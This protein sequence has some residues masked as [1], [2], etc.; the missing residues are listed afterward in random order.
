MARPRLQSGSRLFMRRVFL[1]TF[2]SPTSRFFV[3]PTIATVVAVEVYTCQNLSQNDK[4]HTQYIM[5]RM[6]AEL[7]NRGHRMCN[8]DEW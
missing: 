7:H 5:Y 2:L 4:L 3:S 1:L 6:L 8:S